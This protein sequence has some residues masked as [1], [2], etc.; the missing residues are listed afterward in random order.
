MKAEQQFRE[1]FERLKSDT[2]LILSK[3]TQVTQNNVAREAGCDTSALRKK[4]YPALVSEIQSWV[5]NQENFK[6]P[7]ET[8]RI[9]KQ[10]KKNRT[11]SER[12]AATKI[13]HDIALS[14]LVEAD[15][16]IIELT[17]ENERLKSM[18]PPQNIIQLGQGKK[19]CAQESSGPAEL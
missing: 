7:S 15:A 3:G 10:R 8:Q 5:E 13:T 9:T 18:I 17:M 14:M 4:R 6:K 2:P 1:A 19:N 11:L 12:L 16:K